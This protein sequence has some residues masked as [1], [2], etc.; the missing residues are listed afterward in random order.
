MSCLLA[1]MP[2]TCILIFGGLCL[3]TGGIISNIELN[4]LALFP[5]SEERADQRSGSRGKL[6]RRNAITL[7]SDAESTHPIIAK[8]LDHPFFTARKEGVTA[9]LL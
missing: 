5:C 3:K 9:I 8:S 1:A 2:G 7:I 4:F 6:N